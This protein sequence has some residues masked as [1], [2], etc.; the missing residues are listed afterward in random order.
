[1]N[2]AAI[3]HGAFEN[4]LRMQNKQTTTT[5]KKKKQKIVCRSSSAEKSVLGRPLNRMESGLTH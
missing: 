1:L 3:S 4:I 2:D 5:K